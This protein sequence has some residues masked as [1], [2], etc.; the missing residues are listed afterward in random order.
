MDFVKLYW[1]RRKL[2]EI[3]NNESP[4]LY[5][6]SRGRNIVYIGSAYKTGLETEINSNINRL[7]MGKTGLSIWIAKITESSNKNVSEKMYSN[8]E[9]LL[10]FFH[11]VPAYLN[12]YKEYDLDIYRDNFEVFNYECSLLLQWIKINNGGFYFR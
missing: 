4:A 10:L 9:C 5:M 7:K 8:A 12:G 3:R 1:Q 6:F 11:K 2:E